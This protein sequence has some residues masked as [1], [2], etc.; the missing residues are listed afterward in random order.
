MRKLIAI[1]GLPASGKTTLMKKF[2]EGLTLERIEP[3]KLVVSMHDQKNNLTIHGDYSDPGEKFPGLDRWSMAVQPAAVE[4]LKSTK[5]NIL[6]EGDRIFTAS[7]LEQ[8][9]EL[10][11]ANELELHVIILEADPK[12]VHQRHIDRADTQTKQF[13]KGRDTKYDN[14]RA[15][16]VLM[17]YITVMQ[18][19]T[20]DDME[21]TLTWLNEKLDI[22]R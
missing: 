16:F 5:T 8:A 3:V 15:S 11:D 21:H 17:P 22:A 2:M 6:F 19:N 12:I 4:F 9:G 10:A 14:I 18:N 20:L 1:G 13:L 7:Y